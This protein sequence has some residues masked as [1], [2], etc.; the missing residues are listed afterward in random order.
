VSTCLLFPLSSALPINNYILTSSSA[1][2][3]MVPRITQLNPNLVSL[4]QIV[5]DLPS[6]FLP[7]LPTPCVQFFLPAYSL[8]SLTRHLSALQILAFLEYIQICST[9]PPS[10]VHGEYYFPTCPLAPPIY[11]F[12]RSQSEIK[13]SENG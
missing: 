12:F 8:W 7:Q 10:S 1:I 9:S 4:L 5:N 3:L 11:S 13:P 6:C 2:S